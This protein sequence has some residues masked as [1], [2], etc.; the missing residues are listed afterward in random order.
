MFKKQKYLDLLYYTVIFFISIYS[1][2]FGKEYSLFHTDLIHWNFQLETILSFI[3]G[4]QLYKEIFLQY[5]E[6]IVTTLGIINYFYKIDLYSLGIITSFIFALRFFVIYKISLLLIHSKHLSLILTL[7]V[8]LSMSYSQV[9]WPDFFAGFF[10]LIFFY[11]LIINNKKNNLLL[12]IFTSFLLF[13]TIYF[14]N[15]YILNFIGASVIYLLLNSVFLRDK[16]NYLNQVIFTTY[17]ITIIYFVVLYANDNLLLWFSQGL[18]FSDHFFGVSDELFLERIKNY[19]YYILRVIYYILLPSDLPNLIFSISFILN[20]FYLIWFVIFSKNTIK[21]NSLIIFISLY[22][23]CGV[24][25][26]FSHYEIFR[27]MNASISIYFVAFYFISKLK[28]EPKK[29]L[30]L[31][32]F[33]LIIF[34]FNIVEKLPTSSHKHK[35][36]NYPKE[37]Y[38]ISNFEIFGN[39]KF[40][41]DFIKYYEDL[42]SIICEKD[43]IY[44]LSYDKALNF[45]CESPK[46]TISF[47]IL[48]GDQ[49]LIKELQNGLNEKSRAVVSNEKINDLKL[50]NIKTF[51][52]YLR[53]TLSDTYMQFIPNKLYIYE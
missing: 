8:F 10:L 30:Y 6:G 16:N 48:N 31:M 5:G 32:F 21:E 12:V 51:P 50:I 39:K 42:K 27:Y 41:K 35:I 40:P 13:L 46:E 17:V 11:F 37:Y 14:R 4:K 20:I 9:P 33:C 15:T 38:E 36:T 53:Y 19:I 18:G 25:Q 49:N 2:Y 29:K 45:I 26:T 44:N 47:S 43:Y 22:G 24:V 1:F 23:L 52:K 3:N 7:F 34:F 28:F